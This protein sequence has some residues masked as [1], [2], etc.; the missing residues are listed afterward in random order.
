MISKQQY[1]LQYLDL[2]FEKELNLVEILRNQNIMN[3]YVM[4]NRNG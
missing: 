1:S 3:T 2:I 4:F